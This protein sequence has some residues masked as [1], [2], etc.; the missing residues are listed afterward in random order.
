[1]NS[2]LGRLVLT[3]TLLLAAGG[4]VA[5]AGQAVTDG[6]RLGLED[7]P[8]FVTAPGHWGS[9]EWTRVSLAAGTVGLALLGDEGLRAFFQ[10]RRTAGG[11]RVATVARSFGE[12]LGAAGAIVVGSYV[13]GW[14]FGNARLRETG[15]QMAEAVLFSGAVTSLGKLAFGR[16]RPREEM[17]S[18]SFRPL[19]GRLGYDHSSFPSGHTTVAFAVASVAAERVR[20]LGWAAYPLAALV[21]WSRVNDDDHWV[22]DVVA[23]A[24][25]GTATGWWVTHRHRETGWTL[26]T[27]GPNGV[28][29]AWRHPW[30]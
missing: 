8:D 14:A 6:R 26:W 2:S 9:V 25:L 13:G 7:L 19:G 12:P 1:M 17:G 3:V 21:G 15:F 27:P 18:V 29:V 30:P 22:S 23:A 20:G 24:L 16:S 28:G 4:G 5:R 11:D 10:G